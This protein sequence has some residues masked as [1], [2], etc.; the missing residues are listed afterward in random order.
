M[1]ARITTLWQDFLLLVAR[2]LVGWLFVDNGWRKLM[3]M[4]PFIQSLSNRRVPYATFWGWV[5]ALVEFIGGLALMLGFASR[6]AALLLILFVIVATAI[7][8]RYWEFTEPAARRMQHG[9]FGKNLALIGG[10][11]AL[12]LTGGGRWSVDGWRGK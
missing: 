12:V 3:A 11:I 10:M 7:S 9:Q 6:Y 4:D 1:A 5:G 2:L 8:H